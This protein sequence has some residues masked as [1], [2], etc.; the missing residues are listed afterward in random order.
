MIVWTERH[1]RSYISIGEIKIKNL[2]TDLEGKIR[3][4][5]IL[6]KTRG[7]KKNNKRF[8]SLKFYNFDLLK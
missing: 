3:V 7:L 8:V 1:Q 6:F 4:V 5:L 2:W